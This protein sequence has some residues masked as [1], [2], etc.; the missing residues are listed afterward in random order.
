MALATGRSRTPFVADE[1]EEEE[2]QEDGPG[3]LLAIRFITGPV[4]ELRRPL[5]R[6]LRTTRVRAGPRCR[7][8]WRPR[9]Q[10]R[11][12]ATGLTCAERRELSREL[13]YTLCNSH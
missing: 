12:R 11:R 8:Y 6:G 5:I 4:D 10:C 3:S 13:T 9:Q 7:L 1:D 2:E